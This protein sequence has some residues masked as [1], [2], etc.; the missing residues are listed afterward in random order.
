[1]NYF[2][3]N[4]LISR[5][6]D[7]HIRH[8]SYAAQALNISKYFSFERCAYSTFVL[9]RTSFEHL[10]VIHQEKYIEHNI[11]YA[12][13]LR[14]NWHFP[15][16]S[17]FQS[18]SSQDSNLFSNAN[19]LISFLSADPAMNSLAF[20]RS[21]CSSSSHLSLVHCCFYISLIITETQKKRDHL[22]G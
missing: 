12:A 2:E 22:D 6:S 11:C 7:V 20:S 21:A 8:S 10:Q 17:S 14:W 19:V 16:V 9:R 3:H 15:D 18:L 1:M 13:G 5:L 4:Q